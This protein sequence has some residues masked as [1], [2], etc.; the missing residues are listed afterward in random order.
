VEAN[1]VLWS[2]KSSVSS[3]T[4]FSFG[5][6]FVLNNHKTTRF[7]DQIVLVI[8]DYS[9]IFHRPNYVKLSAFQ[10]RF[11]PSLLG[12][13]YRGKRKNAMKKWKIILSHY[14]SISG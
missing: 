14:L 6:I 7:W 4:N 13:K 5:I 9:D 12:V 3:M 2:W 11:D 8:E 1:V 10:G